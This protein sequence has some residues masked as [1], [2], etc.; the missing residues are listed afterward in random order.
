MRELA[1]E[2]GLNVVRGCNELEKNVLNVDPAAALRRRR[3]N[4]VQMTRGPGHT[5]FSF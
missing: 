1:V 3:A 4:L 5:V 2:V